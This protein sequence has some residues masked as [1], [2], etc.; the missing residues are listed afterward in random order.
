MDIIE[1]RVNPI[2]KKGGLIYKYSTDYKIGEYRKTPLDTIAIVTTQDNIIMTMYPIL[3][4]SEFDREG[5][6]YSEELK[7]KRLDSV[8]SFMKN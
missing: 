2:Y 8:K 3:I 7:T 1:S 4:S 5:I 6:L